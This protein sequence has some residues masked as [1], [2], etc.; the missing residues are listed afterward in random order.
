MLIICEI[1]K[2]TEA[3][4]TGNKRRKERLTIMGY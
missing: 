2:E 1:K 3:D 4:Y